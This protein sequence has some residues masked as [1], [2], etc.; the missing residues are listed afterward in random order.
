[1]VVEL[2]VVDVGRVVGGTV[3]TTVGGVTGGSV[4][5]GNVVE[6]V[7]VVTKGTGARPTVTTTNSP[8]RTKVPAAG[9]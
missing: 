1:V 6:V 9:D 4:V 8:G 5:G 2:V 7:V 3:V